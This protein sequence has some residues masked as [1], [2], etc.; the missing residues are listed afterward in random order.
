MHI[1]TAPRQAPATIPITTMPV[2]EALKP[3]PSRFA[4]LHI[5]HVSPGQG[6]QV[7]LPRL[8]PDT[9]APQAQTRSKP[10][11]K[12]TR[13][14]RHADKGVPRRQN[15]AE[16][17]H[18]E[19]DA[20]DTGWSVSK[21]TGARLR[22]AS[23]AAREMGP[24]SPARW[25][26][27]LRTGQDREIRL[28]SMRIGTIVLDGGLMLLV[29]GRSCCWAPRLVGVSCRAYRL[30]DSFVLLRA[31][32]PGLAFGLVPRLILLLAMMVLWI[33][34]LFRRREE[35]SESIWKYGRDG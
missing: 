10:Y 35:W 30:L 32:N 12:S 3:L 18:R 19:W 1:P 26:R 23:R 28:M 21:L 13:D 22:P 25:R 17:I 16:W 6:R 27:S 11:L 8:S 5:I 4:K 31:D 34:V 20:P 9:L 7:A 15:P 2:T 24:R 14:L 29:G 33:L